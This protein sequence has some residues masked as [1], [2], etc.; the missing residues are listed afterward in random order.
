MPR[1]VDQGVTRLTWVSGED[2]IANPEAPTVAELTGQDATDLTCLMVTTYEVRPD[3]SE[4]TNERSVCE[5]ANV[6][7]P[8]VQ[9]YMG[10]FELFRQWDRDAG[11][12]SASEDP[13]ALFDFGDVGWFV[14][15]T[16]LPKED[17]YAAGQQVEVYKF[18]VDT[19]QPQSGTG[20]GYVKVTVPLLQQGT[21][22][23]S[24]VVD[25]AS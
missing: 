23:V 12:W 5:T 6:D 10:R 9:N 24:A 17:P 8:T 7:T 22:T 21:F 18:M 2:G 4:T 11:D 25:D 13:L 19:P 1:L 16:G 20:S 15:R 14:R 3:A